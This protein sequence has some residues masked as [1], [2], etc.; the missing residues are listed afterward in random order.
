MRKPIHPILRILIPSFLSMT[1]ARAAA[2]GLIESLSLFSF[3]S[4]E[5]RDTV[6]SEE[7]HHRGRERERDRKKDPTKGV[8]EEDGEKV[9][10]RRRGEEIYKNK[11]VKRRERKEKS[12]RLGAKKKAV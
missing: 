12:Y 4:G 8:V 1:R 10:A 7:V 6:S 11:E 5:G 2:P 3:I 9:E